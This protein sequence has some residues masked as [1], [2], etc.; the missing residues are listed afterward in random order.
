MEAFAA[1]TRR[2]AAA[3]YLQTPY[4]WFPIEPHFLAPFFH[5][6]PESWR[7]K[8]VL[9]TK[10]GHRPR[11]ASIGEAMRIIRGVFLL[12]RSQLCYL[13]PDASIQ[14]ERLFFLPKSLIAMKI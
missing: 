12:D 5:W 11:A 8:I 4:F 14:F 2:L 3:Y 1:E 10:L 13:L 6:L 7:S 9:R